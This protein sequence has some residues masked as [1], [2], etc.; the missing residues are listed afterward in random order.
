MTFLNNILDPVE[1]AVETVV[2]GVMDI[3]HQIIG[4]VTDTIKQGAGAVGSGIS[5][6]LKP[7]MIPL[8]IGG[9]IFL[10]SLLIK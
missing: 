8:M 10:V 6:I 3:N 7:L 9:A 2:G 4:G 1:G 5:A